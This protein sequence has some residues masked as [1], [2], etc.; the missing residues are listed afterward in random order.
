MAL[1][2]SFITPNCLWNVCVCICDLLHGLC[3]ISLEPGLKRQMK[4]SK[5]WAMMT[6]NSH[7]LLLLPTNIA[8]AACVCV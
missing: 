1:C 5:G 8:F 4:E 7:T 6:V 2:C 3:C